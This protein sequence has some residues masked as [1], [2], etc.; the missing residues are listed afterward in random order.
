MQILLKGTIVADKIIQRLKD[1]S[2]KRTLGI[3]RVGSYPGSSSYLKGIKKTASKAEISLEL[4]ELEKNAPEEEIKNSVREMKESGK[5]DGILLM[6]PLP[7]W[8]PIQELIEIVGKDLDVEGIHPYNLGKTLLG[9]SE[10][11]ISTPKAVLELMDFYKIKPEGK[12]TVI[13]GR[14]NVVG[15]PLA[16]LLLRKGQFGNATVTV[17]HSRTKDLKKITKKADILIVSIGKPQFVTEEFIK[18]GAIVIDVGINEKEGRITGDV[19]FESVKDKSYA[20]TPVPGGVGSITTAAL[21]SN[22]YQL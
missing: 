17:C 15:K 16:N 3:V 12:N 8:A 10:I 11:I 20:V 6:E 18:E 14:S 19:D 22:L 13:L 7:T 21:L 4:L 1:F 2:P 5:V 9:A